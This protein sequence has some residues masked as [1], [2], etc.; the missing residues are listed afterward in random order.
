[1][2]VTNVIIRK[3]ISEEQRMKGYGMVLQLYP[4]LSRM[5]ELTKKL[6]AKN[7]TVSELY[8]CVRLFNYSEKCAEILGFNNVRDM[9]TFIGIYGVDAI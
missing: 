5:D 6:D 9:C 2:E 4:K 8:E 7:A 3:P 1:M